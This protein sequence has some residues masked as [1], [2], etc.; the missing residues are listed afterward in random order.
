LTRAP[1]VSQAAQT[2][3]LLASC[4]EKRELGSV[5]ARCPIAGD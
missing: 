3:M 1:L 4:D 5:V 2:L